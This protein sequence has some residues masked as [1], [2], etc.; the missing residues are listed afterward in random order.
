MVGIYRWMCG[1]INAW[2]GTKLMEYD[3][4]Y[5]VKAKYF[6]KVNCVLSVLNI[7]ILKKQRE[8]TIRNE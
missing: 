6:C 4:M 8:T 7:L 5:W 1:W 3:R 2:D